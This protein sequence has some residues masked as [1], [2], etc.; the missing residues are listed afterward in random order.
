M[1]VIILLLLFWYLMRVYDNYCFHHFH[2][3]LF[4]IFLIRNYLDIISCRLF[5]HTTYGVPSERRCSLG[6]DLNYRRYCQIIHFLIFKNIFVKQIESE[7]G[8]FIAH[9]YY[10][11]RISK[12]LNLRI[13]RLAYPILSEKSNDTHVTVF[14]IIHND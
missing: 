13:F 11:L 14:F 7:F 10:E 5:L 2:C 9:S 6:Y 1:Y 3:L 12:T 4:Q 8:K